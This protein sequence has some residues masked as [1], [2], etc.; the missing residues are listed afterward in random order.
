MKFLVCLLGILLLASIHQVHAA[1]VLPYPSYMPGN[2]IY[3][4]S[5]IID[6]VKLVWSFGSIAQSKAHMSLSDKY[7]VEAKTLFEYKQ[8]LL[9]VD[10]LL[11]SNKEFEQLPLF[12]HR[13]SSERKDMSAIIIML[14]EEGEVHTQIL[15][16][17]ADIAPKEFLWNPEKSAATKL[18]LHELIDGAKKTRKSVIDAIRL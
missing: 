10:A 6:R 3:K 1:Y 18:S 4:I 15:S 13:G 12:I 14:R 5:R 11:R 9:G 16:G 7:L 8:Y 2:K 17:M